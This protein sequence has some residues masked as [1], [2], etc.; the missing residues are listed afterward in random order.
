MVRSANGNLNLRL[1]FMLAQARQAELLATAVIQLPSIGASSS[2]TEVPSAGSS[3]SLRDAA[4]RH[5]AGSDASLTASLPS[6]AAVNLFQ[7]AEK[8]WEERGK[9]LDG[10]CIEMVSR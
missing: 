9:L 5:L 3:N 4:G 6:G 1:L 8:A 10:L 7:D 2:G